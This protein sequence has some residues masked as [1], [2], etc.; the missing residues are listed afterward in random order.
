MHVSEFSDV[1]DSTAAELN[2]P[3]P[4][5]AY[6]PGQVDGRVDAQP[7]VCA[8]RVHA[9]GQL[10]LLQLAEVMEETL[11][12]GKRAEEG[13]KGSPAVIDFLLPPIDSAF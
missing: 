4:A 10:V 7:R 6:K 1:R 9:V 8:A 2:A 3:L 11:V 5:L 12:P 13:V